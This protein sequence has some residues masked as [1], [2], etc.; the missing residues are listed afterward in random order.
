[1]AEDLRFA[2][3][4]VAKAVAKSGGI[5]Q[6]SGRNLE[7][8]VFPAERVNSVGGAGGSRALEVWRNSDRRIDARSPEVIRRIVYLVEFR[9]IYIEK[10]FFR[11]LPNGLVL[12][13][14]GD[15]CVLPEDSIAGCRAREAKR[16]CNR[17]V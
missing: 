13:A 17:V 16:G 7:D 5:C 10:E 15:V 1:L 12:P 3:R 9:M 14:T 4:P 8:G 11:R 2:E 6:E